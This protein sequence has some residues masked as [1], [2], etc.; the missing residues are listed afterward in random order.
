MTQAP[1]LTII[2]PMFSALIV[3]IWGYYQSKVSQ[4]ITLMALAGSLVAAIQTM[5]I[6]IETGG[7]S[8]RL[9]AWKP[10]FGIEFAIDG[11]NAMVLLAICA[12]SFLVAI[13]AKESIE[14]EIPERIPQFYTL[15]L[16]LVAGLIGMTLTGDAFNLYV[17]IEIVAL[18]GYTL[19]AFGKGRAYL[20]SFNYIILG[21]IGACFYLLGVGYLYIKTGTLNMGDLS[22]VLPGLSGSTAIMV[23]FIFILIG[24]WIKMGFFP[25]HGWLPNAY[26]YAPTATTCLLAPLATKVSVYV[27]A[28]F[29]FGVFSPAYV[30]QV[31][32]GYFDVVLMAT[33][34][35]IAGSLFALAQKNLKKMMTYIIVAEVAY[36]VGGLWL[37]N[38]AGVTGALY[39]IFADAFMTVTFA[40]AI[41]AIAYKT[42][43]DEISKLTGLFKRMP[44]TMIVFCISGAAIIGIPPTCGFFSKYYLITGAV[45][46]G[47]WPFVIALLFSSLV[48]AIIIFRI[49]E[50]AYF[51]KSRV[52]LS[53]APASMLIPMSIAAVS[54]LL[55]GIFNQPIITK[56]IT[57]TLA[58]AN[59]TAQI[60]G[61]H[62][63]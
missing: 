44:M 11:L 15:F 47:A 54:I 2:I 42:G 20:A 37:A 26:T 33:I 17:L 41:G 9:G 36:M 34:A 59:Q 61:S 39:H 31:F 60:Q 48:N 45:Q 53:E 28:R 22:Q 56:L 21:T 25:L 4:P 58:K 10:P 51:K 55:I 12:I 52:G 8:Y 23:A 6:T 14:K 7:I 19:I 32:Q 62:H 16:L 30:Y 29:M 1:I 35:I 50:V 24:L 27:L 5:M 40:M 57:P 38:A 18:T 46:A 43:T 49:I 3:S 63:K 13:Y